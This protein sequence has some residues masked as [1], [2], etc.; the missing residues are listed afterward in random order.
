MNEKAQAAALVAAFSM[1]WVPLG[2]HGFLLEHWMKVGTFMA[3]FLVFIA[4]AF[5]TN[6]TRWIDARLLSLSLLIAY[7]V[8]QF[9]EHWVDL[10]GQIFAFKPYLNSFLSNILGPPAGA[11]YV[12]NASIFVI[13]T[14]LVWLVGA[15]AVWRGSRHIFAPLCMTAIVVVNAISHIGAAISGGS[16][17]PGLL[18][19]VLVF[20]PLGTFVYVALVRTGQASIG[21]VFASLIWAL[22]GHV[23]M[24]GGFVV[25]SRIEDANELIYFLVLIAWSLLPAFVFPTDQRGSPS[26]S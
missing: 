10:Y 14:S 23:V 7:I 24:I 25:M 2:Q 11:E 6:D 19:A 16:Y 21:F 15:L 12:S 8:H 17:N 26:P 9:E 1:L 13:N 3:P 5:K 4:F 20:L 18:T 22:L